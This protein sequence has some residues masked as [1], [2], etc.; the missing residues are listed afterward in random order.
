MSRCFPQ[1]PRPLESITHMLAHWTVLCLVAA[2][3]K[4][5]IIIS[6]FLPLENPAQ[7]TNL[8]AS[9]AMRWVVQ[10]IVH[11]RFTS[12]FQSKERV[13]QVENFLIF[14]TLRDD[15]PCIDH[16]WNCYHCTYI[17]FAYVVIVYLVLKTP[18]V[19]NLPWMY[20]FSFIR[21]GECFYIPWDVWCSAWSP[22][23]YLECRL[24]K[25]SQHCNSW[26]LHFNDDPISCTEITI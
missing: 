12:D 25:I 23:H 5:V 4:V 18:P 8:F 22:S 1:C 20:P 2:N 14:H 13:C 11:G 21:L 9:A 15:R 26:I 7:D 10:R 3:S 19:R 6:K 24:T 17:R 16:I